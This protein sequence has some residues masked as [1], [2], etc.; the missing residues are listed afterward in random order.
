MFGFG[1]WGQYRPDPQDGWQPSP[2][3][4]PEPVRST[5]QLSDAAKVERALAEFYGILT[6]AERRAGFDGLLDQLEQRL[7][8][9]SPYGEWTSSKKDALHAARALVFR[10]RKAR[11]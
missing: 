10:L 6:E 8:G 1:F 7:Q 4:Q 11:E 9:M 5:P 2:D 3:V